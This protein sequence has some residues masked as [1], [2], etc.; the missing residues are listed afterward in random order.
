MKSRVKGKTGGYDMLA[1][2]K[3]EKKSGK[4]NPNEL[5]ISQRPGE[6]AE[7]VGAR[8]AASSVIRGA[9]TG[10]K[11]AEPL[12]GGNVDLTSY[13]EELTRHADAVEAGDLSAVEAML[14]TQANTL[15]M[16]FNQLARK[17][18]YPEYFNQME[19]NLRLALKAQAQCRS[20]L[21]ALVEIKNPRPTF[22]KQQ[23]VGHNVQVNNG[24]GL[25]TIA[26][27]HENSGNQSNELL[28]HQH[29]KWLDTGATAEAGRG[30]QALATMGESDRAED[31]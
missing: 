29:G 12:F 23:N 31:R 27:A 8:I 1:S 16:I 21:E 6:S 25:P 18:A 22:V 14:M 19:A 4:C 30:N 7:Q 9:A 10:R 24:A 2:Q 17:S 11:Y 5:R 28:E 26:H 20:T 15:D 3:A 13:A